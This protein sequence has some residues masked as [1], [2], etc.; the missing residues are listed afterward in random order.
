[1]WKLHAT[2]TTYSH[3]LLLSSAC[4]SQHQKKI[5]TCVTPPYIS[6]CGVMHVVIVACNFHM[7]FHRFLHMYTS[8]VWSYHNQLFTVH[9]SG[10]YSPVSL[11][12]GTTI[13][14]SF[15]ILMKCY[16]LDNLTEMGWRQ[17]NLWLYIL[18]TW[19]QH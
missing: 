12:F 16:T 14:T 9:H 11:N 3:S 7:G 6:F 8:G 13:P 17:R 5:T 1:M 10:Y 19:L 15:N 2:I 4:V 18:C